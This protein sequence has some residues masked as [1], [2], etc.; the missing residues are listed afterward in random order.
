LSLSSD[1]DASGGS[2][3]D[4]HGGTSE[5]GGSGG[6]SDSD[7]HGGTSDYNGSGGIMTIFE[8][9]QILLGKGVVLLNPWRLPETNP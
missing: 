9:T 6:S 4:D 5:Y 8:L 3:S 7:D 2:D 1:N